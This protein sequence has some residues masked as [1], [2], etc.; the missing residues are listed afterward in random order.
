MFRSNH[1]KKSGFTLIELLVVIAIIAI[2]I[3]LLLPAVQKVREAAAR[4]KC[5]NQVKQIALACHNYASARNDAFPPFYSC[6]L[7]AEQQVFVELLPYLEANAAYATF[8][9]PLNLQTRGTNPSIGHD[10]VVKAFQCPSDPTFGDGFGQRD[11]ASGCYAANYQVFGNPGAGN[12]GSGYAYTQPVGNSAGS[13]NLKSSFTDGTSNT[14]IFTEIGAQRTGGYWTL[15]AHG[16][17]NNAWAPIFAYGSADGSTDYNAVAAGFTPVPAPTP[18]KRF[19]GPNSVFVQLT[20]PVG[21]P[22]GLASTYHQTM[23]VGLADGSVRS[24]SPSINGATWW[25][26]CTPA[27]GDLPGNY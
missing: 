17:W 27:F 4:S 16:G 15:W 10:I 6:A 5:Q 1:R 19:V 25:A 8:G 12:N 18:P 20:K 26:L 13:P 21:A 22:I 11:W 14:I 24:L 23:V 9:Q 3:G 7:P 2:L